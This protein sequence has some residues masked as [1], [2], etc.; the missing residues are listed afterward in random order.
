MPAFGLGCRLLKA[1]MFC[2]L[3]TSAGPGSVEPFSHS[4]AGGPASHRGCREGAT[5]HEDV[6]SGVIR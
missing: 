6:M 1:L 5:S 3:A 2:T 4:V